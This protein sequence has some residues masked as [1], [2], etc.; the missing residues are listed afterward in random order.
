MGQLHPAAFHT[1]CTD[2]AL[3]QRRWMD[4][5]EILEEIIEDFDDIT[6]KKLDEPEDP[7]NTYEL[8]CRTRG[9]C[10]KY[11][12]RNKINSIQVLRVYRA[13]NWFSYVLAAANLSSHVNHLE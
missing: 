12:L 6:L 5:E 8:H 10:F 1:F 13:S 9:S 4:R 3:I 11:Y 2:F 7:P